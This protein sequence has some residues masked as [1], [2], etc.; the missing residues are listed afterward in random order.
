MEERPMIDSVLSRSTAP[1]SRTN[2]L[3]PAQ[4]LETVDLNA[5]VVT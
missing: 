2:V 3:K 4:T 1:A 5:I